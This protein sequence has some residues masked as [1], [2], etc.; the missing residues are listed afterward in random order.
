MAL[1]TIRQAFQQAVERIAFAPLK[2]AWS[3]SDADCFDEPAVARET[4]KE[5]G[6]R[7]PVAPDADGDG[8]FVTKESADERVLPHRR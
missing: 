7:A 8:P 5:P 1:P 3:A 6:I 4:A 2:A